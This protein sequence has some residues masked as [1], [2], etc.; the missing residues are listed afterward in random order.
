M[1]QRDFVPE[2]KP[3]SDVEDDSM[4]LKRDRLGVSDDVA[5][6]QVAAEDARLSYVDRLLH[7]A[8]LLRAPIGFAERVIARLKAQTPRPPR[9]EEG[10]GIAVGL[11]VA[12]LITIPVL[13]TLASVLVISLFDADMRDAVW[14]LFSGSA[15]SLWDW[16]T[17]LPSDLPALF[18]VLVVF[19][20]IELFFWVYVVWFWRG[21]VRSAKDLR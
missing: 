6:E 11:G 17:K 13:G 21:L 20:V 5:D 7:S 1:T 18:A 16:I 12:A 4:Q 3:Q 10:T 15:D 14:D 9:Y 8:P 19:V 2:E